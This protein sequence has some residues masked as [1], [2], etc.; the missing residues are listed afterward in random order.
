MGNEELRSLNQEIKIYTNPSIST[1]N[2]VNTLKYL[3]E[4]AELYLSKMEEMGLTDFSSLRVNSHLDGMKPWE[5][6]EC[7]I[8]TG[9]TIPWNAVNRCRANPSQGQQEAWTP[10]KDALSAI[11]GTNAGYIGMKKVL[12]FLKDGTKKT[13]G[14]VMV[15]YSLLRKFANDNTNAS[16]VDVRFMVS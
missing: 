2:D 8:K 13:T 6:P 12:E 1:A 4:E 3:L 9:P 11:R 14:W 16:Y 15:E 10:V 5:L 7:F